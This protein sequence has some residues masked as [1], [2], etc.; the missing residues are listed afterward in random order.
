MVENQIPKP[1]NDTI[2]ANTKSSQDIDLSLVAEK[3][4][5]DVIDIGK[6][7]TEIIPKAT[8]LTNRNAQRIYHEK[9]IVTDL[10][11]LLKNLDE[12]LKVMP[13]GSATYG[14]SGSDTNFNICLVNDGNE[15]LHALNSLN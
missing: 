6:I 10:V 14:F 4:L 13:F 8:E 15:I 1:S 11:R 12:N 7:A 9:Q 5:K 2:V 3:E